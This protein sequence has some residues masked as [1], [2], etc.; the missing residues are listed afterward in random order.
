MMLFNSIAA[1]DMKSLF[2][3]ITAQP[4]RPEWTNVFQFSAPVNAM[5][6]VWL[7]V[8]LCGGLSFVPHSYR[9]FLTVRSV[10]IVFLTFSVFSF[11]FICFVLVLS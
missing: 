6:L 3:M 4:I 1:D 7:S 10:W 2:S 11:K 9:V 5:P 8:V